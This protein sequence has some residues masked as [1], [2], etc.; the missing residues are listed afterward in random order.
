MRAAGSPT[1]VSQNRWVVNLV[2]ATR[3]IGFGRTFR[4]HQH[5][6]LIGWLIH[7][8]N[9]QQKQQS[10]TLTASATFNAAGFQC[11]ENGEIS[12]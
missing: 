6:L 2:S 7:I 5:L 11:G 4:M 8:G 9:N 10:E 3:D 1:L 12:E